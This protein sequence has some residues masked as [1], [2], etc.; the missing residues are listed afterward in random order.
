MPD[1]L[2][3]LNK[4][5]DTVTFIDEP[6]QQTIKTVRVD[7]NPHE[8]ALTPDGRKAFVSNAGDN[9][10]SVFDM[11]GLNLVDTMTHPE[12]DF[13]HEG[14]VTPDGRLILAS[15]YAHKIFIIDVDVHKVLRIIPA[16]RM[17]HMVAL[18]PDA[19]QAYSLYL[20]HLGEQLFYFR[21]RDRNLD[22][23]RPGWTQA[24]RHWG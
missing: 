9:T 23:P 10:I 6:D 12:F 13:P 2:I 19:R 22:C 4:D 1:Y 21:Y 3:V 7:K 20:Q 16:Q 14:K 24:G 11:A 5:D 15:T 18:T 17:S 8:V